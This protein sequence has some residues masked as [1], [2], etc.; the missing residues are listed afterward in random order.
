MVIEDLHTANGTFLNGTIVPP[1]TKRPLKVGDVIQIGE[2]QLKV[3]EPL[4][5]NAG[6]SNCRSNPSAAL[7][8][9][10][11][12]RQAAVPAV[13]LVREQRYFK[14][15][16]YSSFVRKCELP[17]CLRGSD[18]GLLV[19]CLSKLFNSSRREE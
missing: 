15:F 1:G 4:P 12:Q 18:S 17:S 6:L 3:L 8:Y 16:P 10:P 19:K 2:V 5:A 11:L 13:E 7:S 9:F 14:S